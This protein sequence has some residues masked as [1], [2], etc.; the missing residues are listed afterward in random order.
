MIKARLEFKRISKGATKI[1]KKGKLD[2]INSVIKYYIVPSYYENPYADLDHIGL[3][4]SN[5]NY[6]D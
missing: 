2:F 6:I 1:V 5:M 4:S 3:I